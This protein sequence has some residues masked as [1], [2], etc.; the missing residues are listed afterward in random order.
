MNSLFYLDIIEICMQ[1][2]NEGENVGKIKPTT[3]LNELNK[4]K[5]DGQKYSISNV[6]KAL[7]TIFPI[8]KNK[9]LRTKTF[10]ISRQEAEKFL[11]RQGI[12]LRPSEH[13]RESII[14]EN[15]T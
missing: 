11:K 7:K 12:L 8:Y 2:I 5:W 10:K 14:I 6:K 4:V 3:I 15:S 13:A 9:R 1:N